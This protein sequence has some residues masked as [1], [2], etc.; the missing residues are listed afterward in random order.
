MSTILTDNPAINV[1]N[2][3][4]TAKLVPHLTSVFNVKAVSTL[5]CRVNA[6]TV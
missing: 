6:K 5:M 3:T 2:L 1:L 4:K